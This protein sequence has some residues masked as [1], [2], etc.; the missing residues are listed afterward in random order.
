M[1][2]FSWIF[3]KNTESNSHI[4]KWI[5]TEMEKVDAENPDVYALFVGLIHCSVQWGKNGAKEQDEQ[6]TQT[7]KQYLGDSTLFA[8]ACYTYYRLEN[9][10]GKNHP[11][12]KKEIL[13]PIRKW[14][15]EK[16]YTTLYRDEEQISQWFKEQVDQYASMTGEGKAL[17]EIQFELIQHILMT[18]GDKFENKN[19]SQ[20][21]SSITPDS[22][23]IKYSIEQYEELYIPQLIDSIQNYCNKN[24][25]NEVMVKKSTGELQE[26]GDYLFAMALL[27][28]KDW[29]RACKA[30]TKVL[31][32]NPEH[33]NALIQRGLL[34]VILQ[35]PV[36]AL[37]DFSKAIAVDPNQPAAYL[38]RAKCYHRKFRRVEKALADYSKAIELA[39]KDGAGYF[40]RGEVYDEM[41]LQAEKQALENK[42]D[43]KYAHVS[44]DF[45]AAINDYSQVIALEPKHDEA[46][47]NRALLYA[48]KA[49][50][51]M[52]V[53]FIGKAI[54]DFEKA[55]SLNWENGYLFKQLDEMKELLDNVS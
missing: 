28:Q 34:Y 13:L 16:F 42:D 1:G 45:W 55:M 11:E 44:E 15:I 24:S 50:A 33:Y 19:L 53:D 9:W 38:H 31:S 47:L 30:F 46:Y 14:S 51:N 26:Q 49:R 10:I 41:V 29:V 4:R 12:H 18:K 17:E 22:Q 48:R 25:T 3:S 52:N 2:I 6:Y 54:A 23:Y 27:A 21:G 40:G 5:T 20:A 36:D 8:I 7:A 43:S 32:A 39:P 35:Q 37:Q